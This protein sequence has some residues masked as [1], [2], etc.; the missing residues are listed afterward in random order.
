MILRCTADEHDY[1][2]NMIE[3]KGVVMVMISCCHAS[4]GIPKTDII[5]YRVALAF[6]ITEYGLRFQDI[7]R[8]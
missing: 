7:D 6:F 5:L 1:G 4:C 2:R 8:L 3:T